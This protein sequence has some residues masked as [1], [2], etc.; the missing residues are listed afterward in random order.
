MAKSISKVAIK[1]AKAAAKSKLASDLKDTAITTAG[2][3]ALEALT[4]TAPTST[5]ETG[6]S[7][8]KE[9]IESALKKSLDQKQSKPSVKKKVKRKGVTYHT[10]NKKKRKDYDLFR[11]Q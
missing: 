11:T 10:T 9:Q 7:T 5:L 8:A 2:N 6:L 4:G 1:G 3:A